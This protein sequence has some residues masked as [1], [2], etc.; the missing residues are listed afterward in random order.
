MELRRPDAS[1]DFDQVL[2]VVQAYD[3]AIYGD[4][5][6]TP[7]ELREE[8][9]GLDLGVDAWV[10]VDDDRIVGVMH[11]RLNDPRAAPGRGFE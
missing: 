3:R 2:G 4:T 10:A 11:S 6:W 5:D 7:E 9:A 1:A 8:W